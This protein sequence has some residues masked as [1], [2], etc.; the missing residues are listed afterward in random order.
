M[1]KGVGVLKFKIEIAMLM[2]AIGLFTVSTFCYSY[3][4]DLASA[5]YPYRTYA[6]P[7]VSLGS[8]LMATATFSYTKRS[9]N[10]P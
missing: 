7:I 4:A 9:K 3:G 8:V 2:A 6:I 1:K 10:S 5:I